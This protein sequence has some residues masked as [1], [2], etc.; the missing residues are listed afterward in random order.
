MVC[1]ERRGSNTKLATSVSCH[2]ML[3]CNLFM[4]QNQICGFSQSTEVCTGLGR[5]IDVIK[6]QFYS[7][8]GSNYSF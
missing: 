2:W 7:Y 6:V 4:Q 3:T 8:V 5:S 1:C